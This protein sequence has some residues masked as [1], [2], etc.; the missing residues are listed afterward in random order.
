M[1]EI[2]NIYC[3]ESC[4][5]EHDRQAAMVLGAVWCPADKVRGVHERI[6]EIKQRHGLSRWLEIKWTSVSKSKAQFYLDLLDYFFDDN[7][8][9]FR[10]LIIPDKSKLDHEAYHHT[11]DAFYYK[12]YF[13]LL[14][15]IIDPACHYNI[16]LDIKDTWGRKKVARLLDVLSNDKYDFSRQIIRKVQT[17]R[18]HEIELVQLADLLIGVISYV[19]R[20]L[21]TNEAKVQMVKRMQQRSGRLLTHTTLPRASKVNLFRWHAGEVE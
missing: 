20:G 10:A 21:T 3:D 8:L 15:I 11:H 4:H 17:V 6:R 13:N 1:S 7:D 18:S 2:I 19:N 14:K 5:L 12:M 16:Y 9:H